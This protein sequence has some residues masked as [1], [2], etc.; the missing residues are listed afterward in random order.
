M[1]PSSRPIKLVWSGCPLSPV[2][3]LLPLAGVLPPKMVQA[4]SELEDWYG[5]DPLIG[6]QGLVPATEASGALVPDEVFSDLAASEGCQGQAL[7]S[8]EQLVVL[9]LSLS[10]CPKQD[11][12][13]RH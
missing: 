13:I 1:Q 9:E 11:G 3:V 2:P 10:S 6:E 4:W 8:A 12:R 5:T 7:T